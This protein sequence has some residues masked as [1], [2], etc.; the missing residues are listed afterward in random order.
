MRVALSNNTSS[1][2]EMRPRSGLVNPA[3]IATIEALPEPDGP[4]SAV[5]PRSPLKA[6]SMPNSPSCFSTATLS[7]SDAVHARAGAA[8]E[9]FGHDQRGERDQN[10]DDDK[11]HRSGVASRHLRKG[12]DG[13]RNRLRL[14]WN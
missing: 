2:S 3:I 13:G 8:A 4:N 14:A 9:P 10:C 12:V 7:M 5:M 6:A 1:P 11:P